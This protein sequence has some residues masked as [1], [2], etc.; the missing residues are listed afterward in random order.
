M[1][2]HYDFNPDMLILGKGLGGGIYPAS[3]VL[4]NGHIYDFCMNST[5]WG[6][7]SSMAISPIGALVA[8][9]VVE[10]AQ[11]SSLLENVARLQAAIGDSFAAL[12]ALYPEI[13]FPGSV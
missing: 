7:M 3:A 4:T 5:K 10:I 8:R 9:K 11:R 13:Y 6:Y 12:C 1:T 2:S